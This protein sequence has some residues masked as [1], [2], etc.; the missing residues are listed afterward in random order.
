MSLVLSSCILSGVCMEIYAA[1]PATAANTSEALVK[2]FSSAPSGEP[3]SIHT[4]RTSAKAGDA[5]TLKGRVMGNLKPF[6]DGRAA[7]I[8]GDPEKLTPCNA[9]PGDSCETP[10][11]ACCDTAEDIKVGTATIQVVD[12]RGR[13]LKESIENV[14]GLKKLSTI[15]VSGTVAPGSNPDLLILNATSIQ[16]KE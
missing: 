3:T 7:F 14:N 12:Q 2:V 16:V 13:V 10:W 6:V 4:A 9:N 1:E 5:L 8:L 11:D 15:T